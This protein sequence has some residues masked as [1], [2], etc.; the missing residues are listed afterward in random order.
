MARDSHRIWEKVKG[1]RAQ[2]QGREVGRQDGERKAPT[3]DRKVKQEEF[4]PE[5]WEDFSN[6]RAWTME[7]GFFQTH[8]EP[9]RAK[10]LDL[11][12]CGPSPTVK[13]HVS[14]K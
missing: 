5:E 8:T 12:L 4:E 9:V 2:L 7:H 3:W 11:S 6:R 14:G 13:K 10:M 1:K